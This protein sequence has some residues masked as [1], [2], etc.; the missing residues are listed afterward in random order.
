[1]ITP[2]VGSVVPSHD[3]A[4]YGHS[5]FGEQLNEVQVG[6]FVAKLFTSGV[7]GMFVS[8]RIA[9]GFVEKVLDISHNRSMADLEVGYFVTPSFRAFGMAN[10]QQTH[11]GIDLFRSNGQAGLPAPLVPVHDVIQ[12]VNYVNLGGGFAYS[13][14]D[15]FD[16]FASF[17]R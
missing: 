7:P 2:Y 15:S 17:S 12:R 16:M 11:G 5:A 9:Y 4:F 8:S 6:T 3:Y 1:M 14:N 10:A 13:I